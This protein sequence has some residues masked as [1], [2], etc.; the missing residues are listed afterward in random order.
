MGKN[1]N[2]R[3]VQAAQIHRHPRKKKTIKYDNMSD[4]DSSQC[5][6]LQLDSE[7]LLTPSL[8]F[9]VLLIFVTAAA[10]ATA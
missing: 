2:K 10:V 7:P 8:L 5:P 9:V 1:A 3:V 4:D 6:L